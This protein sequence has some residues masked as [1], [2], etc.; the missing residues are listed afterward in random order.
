MSASPSLLD[1]PNRFVRG[2]DIVDNHATVAA[3]ARG[4]WAL[5]YDKGR[6]GALIACP[7]CGITH[8]VAP[9]RIGVRGAVDGVVTCVCKWFD[10]VTLDGWEGIYNAAP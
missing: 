2:D 8:E 9:A 1:H 6:P 4:S 10:Y 5:R 7:N 3:P